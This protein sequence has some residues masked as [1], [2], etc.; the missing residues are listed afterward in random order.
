[1][2]KKAYVGYTFVLRRVIFMKLEKD[3]DCEEGVQTMRNVLS[4]AEIGSRMG[5][6]G[7]LEDMESMV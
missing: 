6:N 4:F 3:T 1:M 2:V 7:C 5:S